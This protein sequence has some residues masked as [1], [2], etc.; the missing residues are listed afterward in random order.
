MEAGDGRSAEERRAAAEA[1]Q[2][3]REGRPLP[4]DEAEAGGEGGEGWAPRERPRMS[5]HYGGADVYGRRRLIA[6]ICILIV[7][8]VLF[9]M[10]GGC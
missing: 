8:L 10:L 6:G 1:R 2:R 5:R 4:E 7:A 3:A 9:A